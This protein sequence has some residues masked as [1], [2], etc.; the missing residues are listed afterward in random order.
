MREKSYSFTASAALGIRPWSGGDAYFN[1]EVAHGV[2]PSSL[3]GLGGFSSSEIA[4]TAGPNPT[5]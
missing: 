2:P 3:T 4:R 1:P 5:L